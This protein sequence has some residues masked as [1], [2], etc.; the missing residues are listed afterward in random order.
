MLLLE[1]GEKPADFIELI[2]A[3]MPCGLVGLTDGQK[4]FTPVD[5]VCFF[6]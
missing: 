5:I 1:L 2:F 3:Q 6:K 4:V